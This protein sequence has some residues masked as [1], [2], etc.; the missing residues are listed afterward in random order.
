[1]SASQYN[2]KTDLILAAQSQ[3]VAVLNGLD[4]GFNKGKQKFLKKYIDS[5]MKTVVKKKGPKESDQS[6]LLSA[7]GLKAPTNGTR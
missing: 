2:R 7:F 4:A 5:L 1:M 6:K 3:A